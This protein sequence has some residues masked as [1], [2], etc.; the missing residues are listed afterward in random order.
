MNTNFSPILNKFHCSVVWNTWNTT[1]NCRLVSVLPDNWTVKARGQ[2]LYTKILMFPPYFYLLHTQTLFCYRLF[3]S[4]NPHYYIPSSFRYSTMA[5]IVTDGEKI[6]TIIWNKITIFE[7]RQKVFSSGSVF[8]SRKDRNV[9]N[10]CKIMCTF[11]HI[12]WAS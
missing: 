4:K 2:L 1:N 9:E 10:P 7:R 11:G 3:H 5:L 8:W 6:L 12:I